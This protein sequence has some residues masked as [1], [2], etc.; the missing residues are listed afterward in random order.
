[1][2]FSDYQREAKKTAL[3][4]T[5]GHPIVYPALGLAGES[6]EV[7]DKIKKIFRDHDGYFQDQKQGLVDELGD[8]LWYLSAICAELDTTLEYVAFC[9]IR[10]LESR[11]RRGV[12]GGNGDNR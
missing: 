1:M 11:R 9:N 2:E 12:I 10:K 7:L 5:I 6:G 8:V 3:Y 4:P